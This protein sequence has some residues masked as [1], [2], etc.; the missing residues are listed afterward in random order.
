MTDTWEEARLSRRREK[1]ERTRT[2]AAIVIQPHC[3][4]AIDPRRLLPL[5]WET[6][7]STDRK[8]GEPRRAASD[9]SAAEVPR[10]SVS[11]RRARMAAVAARLGATV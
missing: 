11:E 2:L 6:H 10:L 4:K 9:G 3:R 1:W 7:T 5:P 8:G